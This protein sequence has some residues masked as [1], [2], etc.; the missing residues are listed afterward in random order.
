MVNRLAQIER[1]D[2]NKVVVC[3]DFNAHSTLWGGVRTDLNGEVME[4]LLEEHNLV[5]LNDG[6]GTRLDV[7]TGNM[8]AL[9]LTMVS[10]SLAG[11]CEWEVE[12]ETSV[13]SDH[14]PIKC[15]I[16]LQRSQEQGEVRGKWMFNRAKWELF[17]YICEQEMDKIDLNEDIEEIDT[18]MTVTILE[19][20]NQTISKSKGRM[21]RKAVPWWTEEC[22]RAVKERNK[23]L[24]V[25]RRSHHF[26]TLI[27][28]KQAQA[29]V[30]R[31]IR[32]GK[33]G[34][35]IVAELEEQHLWE[36]FGG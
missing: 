33:A 17:K 7:H 5:C 9:D 1:I 27:E 19:A 22:G 28:Y 2:G 13:G 36:R 31:I 24:K 21:K 20:A 32:K 34:R 35:I 12:E 4:E 29:K 26:R 18:K 14:F 10:R 30:R 23:A 16:A 6:R 25:L 3:G 11:I 15:K 8:S